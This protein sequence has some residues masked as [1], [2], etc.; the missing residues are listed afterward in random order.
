MGRKARGKQSR[1]VRVT[2]GPVLRSGPNWGLFGLSAVGMLLTIYLSWAWWGGHSLRGCAV[3]SS[4]DVALGS[5]WATLLG[6]PTS[7][8]GFFAYA[9]LAAVAFIRRADWHWLAAWSLAL[10]GVCYSAYLTVVSLTILGGACPYC[11]TSFGLMTTIIALVGWQRPTSLTAFSWPRWLAKTLPVAALVIVALHVHYTG[12]IGATS[13]TED[14]AAKALAIH[15]S[16]IGAKMYGA[17]WCPHCQQQK[18][19]FGASARR[20]P[21]VECSTGRQG[22]PQTAV[23]AR[24]N[25]QIYPTWVIGGTRTEE[26]MSLEQLS[27][28]SGA[29][30]R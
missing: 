27:A 29:V 25:I 10:L 24:A 12:V 30:Y 15:L 7:V 11:L 6:V 3:G 26:V 21:Y 23:C 28:A 5:A 22:S 4:C 14:P 18:A 2:T 9:S 17:S 13:G 1:D 20:L 16:N 19:L 8:L